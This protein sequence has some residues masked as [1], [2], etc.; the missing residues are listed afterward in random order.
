MVSLLVLTAFASA[1]VFPQFD[2]RRVNTP[3]FSPKAYSPRFEHVSINSRGQ[4]VFRVCDKET[5]IGLESGGRFAR[6]D[7]TPYIYGEPFAINDKGVVVAD[8]QSPKGDHHLLRIANGR[9][10]SIV[11]FGMTWAQS[12]DINDS[13]TIVGCVRYGMMK[14]FIVK[15]GRY[16]SNTILGGKDSGFSRV[17]NDGTMLGWRDVPRSPRDGTGVRTNCYV[18]KGGKLRKVFSELE[19]WPAAM[20]RAG[21][22][23]CNQAIENHEAQQCYFCFRGKTTLIGGGNAVAIDS[24]GVVLCQNIPWDYPAGRECFLWDRGRKLDLIKIV[25]RHPGWK[26]ETV[27]DM[28]ERG[29]IV[30]LGTYKG[31]PGMFMLTPK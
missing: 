28:N 17:D 26:V 10:T 18:V 6:L 15:G 3:P 22:V 19:T 23:A 16:S 7:I 5:Y 8:A 12:A 1:R 27:C 20:N 24:K 25:Q 4:I 14:A 31:Q 9:S 30:G 2:L 21:A 11:N 29:Q 13:E